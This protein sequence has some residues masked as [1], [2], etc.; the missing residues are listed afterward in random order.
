MLGIRGVEGFVGL[1][2]CSVR[3][4]EPPTGRGVLQQPRCQEG[5]KCRTATLAQLLPL[6]KPRKALPSP[7]R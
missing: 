2:Y 7:E 5:S 4:H 1:R 6:S 3:L